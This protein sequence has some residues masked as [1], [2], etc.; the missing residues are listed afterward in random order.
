MFPGLR[1]Q[2]TIPGGIIDFVLPA[3]CIVE[4]KLSHHPDAYYQ[5]LRYRDT[6]IRENMLSFARSRMVEICKNYNPQIRLPVT[7]KLLDNL[8]DLRTLEPGFHVYI[9]SRYDGFGE[10]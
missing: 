3:C 2:V 1:S 4:C 6:C 10:S 8:D 9:W 5:L 7:P